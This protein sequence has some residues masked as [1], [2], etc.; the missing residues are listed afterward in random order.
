M[1]TPIK[2]RLVRGYRY[3]ISLDE[4]HQTSIT[5]SIPIPPGVDPASITVSYPEPIESIEVGVPGE[6]PFLAGRLFSRV[7]DVSVEP[8]P[9]RLL[10]RLAKSPDSNW[11]ILIR[12]FVS[13]TRQL[14]DPQS[15]LILSMWL[16]VQQ[17]LSASQV[18]LEYAVRCRFPEAIAEYAVCL[19]DSPNG[20]GPFID[21]LMAVAR[22]FRSAHCCAVIGKLGVRGHI[23]I[24]RAL[25]FLRLGIEFDGPDECILYLG[26]LLSPLED[27]QGPWKDAERCWQLLNAVAHY[28]RA[29][30]ARA[31]LLAAGVGC[32]KNRRAARQ[33]MEEAMAEPP[34]LPAIEGIDDNDEE[35]EQQREGGWLSMFWGITGLCLAAAVIVYRF[36]KAHRRP[37]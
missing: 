12:D 6:P 30:Y 14:I 24:E 36:Y 3:E 17:H 31:K 2:P 26:C 27:P 15:A 19:L 11:T 9:T 10:L 37:G 18:F 34:N 8:D 16:S 5:V 28:P 35:R 33:L 32:E 25:E 21:E 20:V 7:S 13:P 29:R 22:D 1:A 23:A 4:V